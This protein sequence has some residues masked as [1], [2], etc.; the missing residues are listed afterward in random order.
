MA[1][2]K[3]IQV[4]EYCLV[5]RCSSRNMFCSEQKPACMWANQT[6]KEKYGFQNLELKTTTEYEVND[7][8]TTSFVQCSE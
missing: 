3:G 5:H 7:P 6:E 2:R 4:E 8:A 1:E